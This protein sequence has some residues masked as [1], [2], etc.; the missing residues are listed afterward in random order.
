MNTERSSML[1]D[2]R[3]ATET[4][5]AAETAG[6]AA[7]RRPV[8]SFGVTCPLCGGSLRVSAGERSINCRYCGSA[9]VVTRPRGV[10]SFMM[11]PRITTGKAR[12]AA[13]QYLADRTGGRVR[14][15]H[16]SIVDLKL[17]HVPFWR[18]NGRLMGWVCG[19]T[20]TMREVEISSPD[21]EGGTTIQSVVEERRPFSKPVFKR[22]D[23]STP[24]CTVRHL[25]LQGISLKTRFLEWDGFDHTLTGDCVFA[26]PMKGVN[27]AREDAYR[28]LTTITTPVRSRVRVSRFHLAD[29]DFSLYYYPVYFIR[30]RHGSRLYTI[31]IDGSDGRILWGETPPHRSIRLA[32]LFFVPAAL[33]FLAGTYLPLVFIAAGALYVA[34]SIRTEGLLPPHR[35]LVSRLDEWFGGDF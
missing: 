19:E 8:E 23:W 31:T 28:Y 33:A 18:M 29:S 26:L 1:I 5:N 16:A 6:S 9:L 34:D 11:Q 21:G 27:E 2:E 10:R 14:A 24:A 3:P 22:V 17:V 15:R 13:L 12:L 7:E 25:G 30:Y 20:S 4:E 32:T 35:W